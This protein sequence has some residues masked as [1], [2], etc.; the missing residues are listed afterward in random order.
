MRIAV[1]ADHN[2]VALRAR[3]VRWLAAEGHTVDDRGGASDAA[4]VVDYPALCAD[5]CAEVV[6]G[7][8][9]RALVL[10]G[11]GLGETVACNKIHGIRAGLCHD[12]WSAGISRGNNDA[13]VLVLAA[14]TL[15]PQAAEEVVA[16]WLT[17]PFKGGVHARRVAQIAALER[18]EPPH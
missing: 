14:K 6:A 3:L 17:T 1:T 15:A 9:D 16:T 11:S 4:S 13:N 7:R 10:G 8:A 12:V 2:G 5:A 18:G